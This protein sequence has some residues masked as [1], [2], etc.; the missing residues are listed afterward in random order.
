MDI[1]DILLAKSMSS[2]GGASDAAIQ[3]A[4]KKVN[5]AAIDAQIAINNANTAIENVEAIIDKIPGSV[6]IETEKTED[7]NSEKIVIDNSEN[8]IDKNY[9]A[10][11]DN[12]D[13]SMTQKAIKAYVES[14][15]AAIEEE[16]Q[17]GI[18]LGENH[19]GAIVIVDEDGSLKPGKIDEASIINTQIATGTYQAID[20]AGVEIN[21]KEGTFRRLQKSS[22][23][24]SG[25]DFNQFPMYGG[26]K[27]CIVDNDG[28]IIAF[29]GEAEYDDNYANG[30]QTMVYIPRFYY[31]RSMIEV[32]ENKQVEKEVLLLS[33]VEQTGFKLH[34]A[35]INED[36]EEIDYILYPAYEGCTFDVS[37][38]AYNL[39]D[40]I[41]DFNEDMLASVVGAK[42]ISGLNNALNIKNAEKL[43]QN[44]GEGWHITSAKAESAIQMLALV[45]FNTLNLQQAIG[46]GIS[47]I[48]NLAN[49]NCS[50]Y[51][52]S[53]SS[54]GNSTGRATTTTNERNGIEYV[55]SEDGQCSI[56][57]RGIEDLYGNIWR[58]VG[59][60]QIIGDGTQQG[61]VPAICDT[62]DYINGAYHSPGFTLPNQSGWISRFG[63][64]SE[65]YDWLFIPNGASGA[66]SL[67]PVGDYVWVQTNLDDVNVVVVGGNW[68]FGENNG[69][70]Y[71]GFD[72]NIDFYGRSYGARI[73]FV[74]KKNAIYNANIAA[75]QRLMED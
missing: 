6:S 56:S 8:I 33:Y 42:P 75:W 12:E 25:E 20:A 55:Y 19:N 11:G 31:M 7:Y 49:A 43:A 30:Y 21:Y 39:M 60:I 23:F 66:N 38:N 72:K 17:S 37:A 44:R 51:T 41:I 54:L 26:M 58:F 10:I 52:G 69:P 5:Q 47:R 53:T 63:Q 45:E 74:P 16:I 40:G 71:Y 2:N 62:Y 22:T 67:L 59:G 1:I 18:N 73:M 34:P 24:S 36:G 27:R 14:V 15:K 50:S 13:G 48:E 65:N 61:G 29:Y 9:K 46:S 4:L 70:F 68:S 57:Y 64:P 35:F 3:K 28:R 32:N